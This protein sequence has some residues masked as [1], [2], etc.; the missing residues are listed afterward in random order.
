MKAIN[1]S[2]SFGHDI[3][4]YY[5]FYLFLLFLLYNILYIDILINISWPFP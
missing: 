5:Y 4:I 1:I 2:W 3:L